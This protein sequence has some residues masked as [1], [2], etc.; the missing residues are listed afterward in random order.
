MPCR[1][2][3]R[4]HHRSEPL[5]EF[6]RFIWW[7]RTERRMAAN[8][9][10]CEFTDIIGSYCLH[11][12]SPFIII[13]TQPESW[14]SFYRP[15][16]GRRLSRPKHCRKGAAARAQDCKLQWLAR[17]TYWRRSLTPQPGTLTLGHCDLLDEWVWTTCHR[18]LPDSMDQ[19]G[20]NLTTVEL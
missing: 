6:T 15:M 1:Y 12:P 20:F 2:L 19:P 7:M 5:Q 11:P 14:Y 8:P 4:C 13:I 3:W 9:Q 17:S 18:V 10:G 16:E